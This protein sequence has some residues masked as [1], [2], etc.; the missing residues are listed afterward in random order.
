MK[1]KIIDLKYGKLHLIKTD[2]F[3]TFNIKVILKDELK[4]EDITKR[5]LLTDYL[6]LT[7]KKYKTRR[8]LALRTEELYS[9]FLGASNNR[10]GNYLITRF[11]LSFL[12]PK[13]TEDNMLEESIGLLHEIIFNPNCKNNSFQED[14]FK[15]IKKDLKTEIETL[16]ENSQMYTNIKM[17]ENMGGNKPYSYHGFGY[18]EDLE[19]ITPSSLYQYY[20]EFIT[21][22]DVDI[23]VCGDL[24]E[25]R[26]TNIVKDKLN[27]KTI[28][29]EKCCLYVGV[30]KARK[31]HQEIVEESNFSQ[32]KLAIGCKLGELSEFRFKYAINIYN[33]ILGGGFNSKFMQEIREKDSLAYYISSYVN[34]ADNI[35]L[36]Q[37][38]ISHKNY[39]KVV[40][41][42]KDIMKRMAKGEIS[43]DEI[44]SAKVE[45]ISI[46][47]EIYDNM[48]NILEGFIV[49]NLM[50]LDDF[51]TRRKMVNEV[52]KE[53]VI[54]VAKKMTIDTIYL[55]KGEDDGKD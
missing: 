45:Y 17:L 1:E 22:C 27:F 35:M 11:N 39:K 30:D 7:T 47:D 4:K 49:K 25:E 6:T 26:V 55:L 51:E 31:R 37:S 29:K 10:V 32:S 48:E 8:E 42:V 15:I 9:L 38:G 54:E 34:K 20:K 50:N 23:Y 36:I 40:S 53:D 24:D 2:K 43:D 13:Y 3:R 16:K 41:S 5:N 33:M 52:S 12:D 28:K 18:L 19:N 14:L 44:K 46:L 21:K